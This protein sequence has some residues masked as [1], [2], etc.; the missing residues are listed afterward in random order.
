MDLE[1]TATRLGWWNLGAT[2]WWNDE[3][4]E[5]VVV[6][7]VV[8]TWCSRASL[9]NYDL[10]SSRISSNVTEILNSRF[11]LEHRYCVASKGG[12]GYEDGSSGSIWDNSL[13][14]G[15]Y[16]GAGGAGGGASYVGV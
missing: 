16:Y 9:K 12:R 6:L 14:C 1:D 10:N 3:V 13:E 4:V 15:V 2:I 11:A 5:V 7:V 8:R